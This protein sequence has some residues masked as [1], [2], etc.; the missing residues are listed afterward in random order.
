MCASG[1][2]HGIGIILNVAVSAALQTPYSDLQ[3]QR[4]Q[5]RRG[6]GACARKNVATKDKVRPGRRLGPQGAALPQ[7]K[8]SGCCRHLFTNS[9]ACPIAFRS[10]ATAT[11]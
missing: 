7:A 11:L 2:G 8:A 6:S 3:L 9:S 4:L 1:F 10:A 5:A